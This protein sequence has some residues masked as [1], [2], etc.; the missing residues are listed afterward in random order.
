MISRVTPKI[1]GTYVKPKESNSHGKYGI[2]IQETYD[3]LGIQTNYQEGNDI[4]DMDLEIKS[5]DPSRRGHVSIGSANIDEVI[6]TNGRCF[7]DKMKKWNL[8]KHHNGVVTSTIHVDFTDI[9]KEIEQELHDLVKSIDYNSTNKCTIGSSNN[10]VVERSGNNSVKLRIKHSRV[11][12]IINQS[13]SAKSL[14]K[15]F[16]EF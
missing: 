13:K 9:S 6:K 4:P 5:W 3:N 15:I 10:F 12:N 2:A 8:H 11:K 7:M 14:N 16:G 1:N